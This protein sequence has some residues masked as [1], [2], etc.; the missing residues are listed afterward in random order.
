MTD[1]PL[2]TA[3]PIFEVPL[4]TTKQTLSCRPWLVKEDR[5]LLAAKE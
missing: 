5:L 1:N 3:Y 4:L 2:K